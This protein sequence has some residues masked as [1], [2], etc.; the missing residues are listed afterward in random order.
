MSCRHFAVVVGK[1][2]QHVCK[3]FNQLVLVSVCLC[4]RMTEVSVDN[5]IHCTDRRNGMQ[6]PWDIPVGWETETESETN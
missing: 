4:E 6:L 2:R 5:A 1:C 3:S